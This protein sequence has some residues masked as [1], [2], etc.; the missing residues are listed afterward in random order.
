M[1]EVCKKE[2]FGYFKSVERN[3]IGIYELQYIKV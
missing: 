1:L 2:Y 3:K